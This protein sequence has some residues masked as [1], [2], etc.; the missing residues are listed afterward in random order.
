MAWQPI[1]PLSTTRIRD[2]DEI[3]RD[4]WAAIQECF[5]TDHVTPGQS[6][7]GEHTKVT[8]RIQTS[9]PTVAP[10]KGVLFTK[11]VTGRSELFFK[12]D[13]S[14]LVQITDNGDLNVVA[15]KTTVNN[16]KSDFEVEHLPNA[17]TNKG[18]HRLVSLV[19]NTDPG[20]L[21]SFARIW[22]GAVGS[23]VELFAR[24]SNASHQRVQITNKGYLNIADLNAGSGITLSANNNV[25]KGTVTVGITS[26]YIEGIANPFPAGTKLWFYQDTA[27]T[28]W[29]IDSSVAD[30]VIAV[31]GGTQAYNV[32]GG[33]LAGTWQQAGH[34]LSVNEIPSHSHAP[35]FESGWQGPF[36]NKVHESRAG[37]GNLW[38]LGGG[39][40]G[41]SKHVWGTWRISSVGGGQTHNHGNT[42]RPYAAVGIICTKN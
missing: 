33:N 4:N 20:A 14:P 11:V 36:Y 39:N 28:G 26:G 8:L 22:G 15:L 6:G 9:D 34:A 40:G 32:S 21:G 13:V 38:S 12:S 35:E 7:T 24:N 19:A 37:D 41:S 30:S 5:N 27:P 16:L 42:W 3:L 10:D 18:R 31:K 2:S 25:A 29:T 17:D 1:L 23:D